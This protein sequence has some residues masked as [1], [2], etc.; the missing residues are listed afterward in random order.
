[1]TKNKKSKSSS[2][3]KSP[4]LYNYKRIIFQNKRFKF[5][6]KINKSQ[7][8]PGMIVTFSYKGKEVHDPNPLVLVLNK[9][10]L[11]KLHGINLNYCDLKQINRI[12]EVVNRKVYKIQEKLGLRYKIMNPYGFYHTGIKPLIKKFGKSVYRTYF[13]SGIS[14]VKLIDFKF[15]KNKGEQLLVFTDKKGETQVQ[16]N[17]VKPKILKIN[18]NKKPQ[19]IQHTVNLAKKKNIKV[20]PNNR[21]IPAQNATKV[22]QVKTVSNV[23]VPIVTKVKEK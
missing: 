9:R 23:A 5:Q 16:L 17:R 11:G 12:A 21:L 13:I 10:W 19:E 3:K 15:Q 20:I 8:Q 1:M 4:R 6:Q 14:Q 22:G 18:L 2:F 7:L